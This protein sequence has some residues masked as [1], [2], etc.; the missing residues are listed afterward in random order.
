PDSK[1]TRLRSAPNAERK[2]VSKAKRP[3]AKSGGF[4][5]RQ[6]NKQDAAEQASEF[7]MTPHSLAAM[8]ITIDRK[9]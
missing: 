7:Q 4:V 5:A 8:M 3:P 1:R 9:T 6:E 2:Q